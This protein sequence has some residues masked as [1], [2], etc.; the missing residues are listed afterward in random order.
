MTRRLIAVA[1]ATSLTGL[2]GC[3][4]KESNSTESGQQA[5][6]AG[7]KAAEGKA[8]EGK[9]A[10][11]KAGE[12]ALAEGVA[13]AAGEIKGANEAIDA[14][15]SATGTAAA[16]LKPG[17]AP[18]PEMLEKLLVGLSACELTER[19]I[20]R[21]CEAWVAFDA[22]R[23]SSRSAAVKNLG[24]IYAD[25]GRKHIKHEHPAVRLQAAS[26][27]GSIFGASK[28]SQGVLIEAAKTEQDPRVLREMIRAVG[29]SVGKNPAV[30]EL[31]L[32]T[33]GNKDDKVRIEVVSWLTSSWADKTEG[34]LE[35]AMEIAEQDTSDDVKRFACKR[36]GERGDE[37]ALPLLKKMTDVKNPKVLED[38]RMFSACFEGVI[39]MWSAP[40][41][42][43][44]PSEAAYKHTLAL[45]TSKKARGDK[46]PPWTVFSRLR[47]AK[48][49]KFQEAAGWY[50]GADVQKALSDIVMDRKTNWMARTG[51]VDTMKELG[52]EKAAFEKLAKAYE[53]AERQDAHVLKKIEKVLASL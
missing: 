29:S 25:L 31:L 20:D 22:A 13:K 4:K 27:M 33:A 28:D 53:G 39:A 50:K 2:A 11:G 9:A 36:L 52:A 41:P 51:A 16:M 7:E 34:T 17:E 40:V 38:D 45:L 8:A 3:G 18:T 35:K 32:A 5:K 44:T 26:M 42:H 1:L 49:P 14:A 6:A 43:K 30:K 23:K 15:K 10:E 47:W 12:K 21:K 19:G 37:R 24:G 48:K 46:N